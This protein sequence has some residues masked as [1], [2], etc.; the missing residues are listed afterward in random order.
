MNLK[1]HFT[2][3]CGLILV[4]SGL[5]LPQIS[6]VSNAQIQLEDL[7]L[8]FVPGEVI[9]KL[10]DNVNAT[11]LIKQ[12]NLNS[13]NI[14]EAVT[15]VRSKLPFNIY[16]L[17]DFDS[18]L[19]G[20][21]AETIKSSK[22]NTLEVISKL[23]SRPEVEYAEPNYILRADAYVS[24]DTHYLSGKQWGLN[25]TGQ[26][27]GTTDKDINA[28]AAW[29]IVGSTPGVK[30]AVLDS[31]VD[32]MHEDLNA[33]IDK[34]N[35]G[36]PVVAGNTNNNINGYNFCA[37]DDCTGIGN[38]NPT[39]NYGHGTHI[40][41]VIA[42]VG[43]NGKGVIGTCPNCKIMPLK[44]I[45]STGAGTVTSITSGIYYAIDNGAKVIN[46]SLGAAGISSQSMRS[47][48]ALAVSR[49]IIVVASGGNCGGS[50]FAQN[51]CSYQN[52]PVFPALD[53]N[54]IAVASIDRAGARSSFSNSNDY[55]SVTAPGSSILSTLPIGKNIDGSCGDSNFGTANDGYG[56][57]S[58]TSMS[59]PF[60]AGAAGL[61]K[62]IYPS[63]SKVEF[64]QAVGNTAKDI[65]TNGKDNSFGYGI[66]DS[67]AVVDSLKEMSGKKSYQFKTVNGTNF[68]FFIG[69]DN[70]LYTQRN[71][72]ELGGWSTPLRIGN[73]TNINALSVI[74]DGPWINLYYNT[75]DNKILHRY[76]AN[77]TQWS[78]PTQQNS[79][80][81]N[82]QFET[83]I[84]SGVYSMVSIGLD[85]NMYYQTLNNNV[86]STPLRI[87][88]E[89]NINALS[90]IIDGPWINLYYNTPDNKILHRYS[91]NGT[92][93]SNPTQQT[94]AT[95]NKQFKTF[96]RRGVYT[97]MYIGMDGNLYYK[98]NNGLEWSSASS[99]VNAGGIEYFD[100]S[101]DG[102]W[103]NI[104]YNCS[105]N[106][107]K[108]RYTV[109]F[110]DWSNP[111]QQNSATTNKQFETFIRSG[112]YSMVSIGL[113]GNMYY[114]TLNNNVWSTPLRIGNETNINALSVIIDGPWINLYYNTPD[115]KILHRYS[116]NGTQWS[117]PTQQTNA[118]TNKQFKTFIRRGVY[119]MMYIGMDGN[120]YYK[121]NNGL[122]WE[123]RYGVRS[124]N[125]VSNFDIIVD[126]PWINL[127]YN[128]S[129]DNKIEQIYSSRPDIYLTINEL[130]YFG[131]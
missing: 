45:D 18:K 124:L 28:P 76:S 31:G 83:F 131:K 122:E 109:D 77:G 49:N 123:N 17:K 44:V 12:A 52:E 71:P 115:N 57:C 117:N 111:T 130:K 93:W 127:Y 8:N 27:G 91:A 108:H 67:A 25:N 88:N 4:S 105:N 87:G 102:P 101:A 32:Y 13:L 20:Q 96:I 64:L 50:N 78:N 69:E 103:L 43:K 19:F 81:T 29:D 47:A 34:I 23:K 60:V 21:S 104:Y 72:S 3:F 63:T 125:N 86:W 75:P 66:V 118:T 10:K 56:Y 26:D 113:D 99:F 35:S 126:G 94:N 107:L 92:Q 9:L 62:S 51:G 38:N 37:T 68:V 2:I 48:I 36:L 121:T 5:F 74:I 53:Q 120:L 11:D 7:N 41:G 85:G 110:I 129:S 14:S 97:M 58:G 1:T 55:I 16:K 70:N 90:V 54:V 33:N 73:E 80:T 112:V 98:T 89:T 95:T 119:T 15:A 106:K 61:F 6:I 42:A 24:N 100:A 116:A 79:A 46:L 82:K 114:Q 59:A 40:A 22:L 39:D 128:R 84:R 65:G 30:V